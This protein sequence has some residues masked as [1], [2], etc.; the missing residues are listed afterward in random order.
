MYFGYGSGALFEQP[1]IGRQ[2]LLT[3]LNIVTSRKILS[4]K[5]IKTRLR[6]ENPEANLKSY[7]EV[8]RGFSW[9]F[10]NDIFPS[11]NSDVSNIVSESVDRW[12]EDPNSAEKTALIFE[13][14]GEVQRLT[15]AELKRESSRMANLLVKQGLRRGDTLVICSKPCP[16][17]HIGVLAC[18][19]IGATSCNLG[20]CYIVEQ[21]SDFLNLV[22]PKAILVHGDMADS[23]LNRELQGVETVLIAGAS[24]SQMSIASINVRDVLPAM[25]P[26]FD[27]VKLPLDEP[28]YQT[29][30]WESSGKLRLITHAHRDMMGALVTGKFVLD[31]REDS[32]L[33]T[34]A[35]PGSVANVT[36]GIFAPLI[37]GCATV[38]QGDSF[39]ASTWYW[40]L[41]RLGVSVWFTDSTKL[42]SL[43]ADGDDLLKGYDFSDLKHMVTIGEPLTAELFQWS[44]KN[45]KRSPH[46]VWMTD[47]TGMVCFANFA[48]E[49]IK[50]GSIG[51]PVPGIHAEILDERAQPLPILTLGRLA[52]KTDFPN[53]SLEISAENHQMDARFVDG[54]FLTGD[55]AL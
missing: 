55:L 49:Q 17:V 24:N 38:I 15:Y 3:L 1:V 28:L 45:F 20:D 27:N 26:S 43:K 16:E 2:T 9:S 37:C 53:L 51:K 35:P 11:Y 46:E 44:R 34:D 8:Y 25:N 54:W 12:A 50:I 48:S 47:E 18:A 42:K 5:M 40:T 22:H 19:R 23:V 21:F 39:V 32:V 6:P 52:L 31:L 14:A 41:E 7:Y 13:Y 10:A 30:N 4:R 29:I 36:Y 33:W